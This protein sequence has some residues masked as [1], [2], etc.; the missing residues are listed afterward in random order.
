[1]G[2]AA[3]KVNLIIDV[4]FRMRAGKGPVYE[5]WAKIFDLK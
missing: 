2:A 3:R 4:Q 5:R 1:M